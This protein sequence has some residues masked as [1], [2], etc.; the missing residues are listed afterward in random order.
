MTTPVTL[1]RSLDDLF[2][3]LEAAVRVGDHARATQLE[4]TILQ[5][6][7]IET[8]EIAALERRVRVLM[9]NLDRSAVV[10]RAEILESV[11]L[12]RSIRPARADGVV[13]PVWFGTNRRP[14]ASGD[15]FTGERHESVSRGRVEVHVP[16]AHRFGETGT[17]LWKRLLRFDLRDDHLRSSAWR[18]RN[19]TRI[20]P[21]SIRRCRLHARAAS[22]R[23][24]WSSC[25]GL[26]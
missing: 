22:N 19:E 4:Q 12:E 21:I 11:G 2:L 25:T 5:R 24:R 17:A 18:T 13:Y 8:A 9:A 1:E 6:L 10:V 3:E 7:V 20:F 26:M 15:G 16:E 23:T 14:T